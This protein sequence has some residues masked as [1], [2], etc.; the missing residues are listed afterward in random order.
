MLSVAL[1]ECEL[2]NNEAFNPADNSWSVQAPLPQPLAFLSAVAFGGKIYVF[3]GRGPGNTPS[4]TVF[5]YDPTANAWTSGATMPTSRWGVGACVCGSE[6]FVMG[7]FN[8]NLS[9]NYL[10]IVEAYNPV[11]D[12]WRQDV[13]PMPTARALFPCVSL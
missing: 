8:P 2:T 13:A 7:G 5:I 1:T 3:G 10:T 6:I 9:P 11:T 4:N 12:T